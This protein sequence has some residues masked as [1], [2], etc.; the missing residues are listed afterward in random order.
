M[1]VPREPERG[2]AGA[3]GGAPAHDHAF[4]HEALLYDGI[5][6]FVD[7]AAAFIREGLAADEPVMVM[8]AGARVD[9]LSEAL[10]DDARRV[11]FVDV[12]DVGRNP[13]RIIPAWRG[14]VSG[15]AAPGR[16]MRGI[17]EPIW[18]GRGQA[19][20]AECQ[21]FAHGAVVRLHMRRFPAG[22]SG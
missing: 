2:G 11:E 15:N 7:Q 22:E 5:W 19:E 21:T 3:P 20:L 10:G 9:R 8:V 4:A 6:Q 17:G 16:V 12:E 18:A 1:G 14:F 13:S